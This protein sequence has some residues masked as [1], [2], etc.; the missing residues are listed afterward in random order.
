MIISKKI[1]LLFFEL[2][3]VGPAMNLRYASFIGM[4]HTPDVEFIEMRDCLQ[5]FKKM[6]TLD[7]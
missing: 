2:F 1:Q 7:R 6:K 5:W 4:R 3:S